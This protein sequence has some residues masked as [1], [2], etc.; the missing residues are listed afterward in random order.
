MTNFS[1]NV[2][3]ILDIDTCEHILEIN[4]WI[5]ESISKAG[6][7]C[8]N[9]SFRAS[10]FMGDLYVDCNDEMEFKEH[11]FGQEIRVY[12]YY[13][14]AYPTDSPPIRFSVCRKERTE[15][16]LSIECQDKHTLADIVSIFRHEKEN[17]DRE[18]TSSNNVNISIENSQVGAIA[19]GNNNHLKTNVEHEAETE[20]QVAQ[21]ELT[22]WQGVWQTIISNTLWVVI[23]SI[24]LFLLIYLGITK[25]D[26][27]AL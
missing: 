14:N 3:A 6:V 25:P 13:L 22:F 16:N 12:E 20:Q 7:D 21:S 5:K 27:L 26:W 24:I 18:H 9:Y 15:K 17:Y 8:D 2:E 1:I 11:T 10:F 4:R 23:A 19:V